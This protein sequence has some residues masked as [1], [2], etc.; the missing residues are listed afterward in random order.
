MVSR[1]VA[2]GNDPDFGDVAAEVGSRYFGT[3]GIAEFTPRPGFRNIRGG[4]I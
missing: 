3:M 2:A 1:S 4:P